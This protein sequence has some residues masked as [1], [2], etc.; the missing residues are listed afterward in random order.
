MKKGKARA[1]NIVAFNTMVFL[2]LRCS[3]S[4]TKK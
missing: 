4:A 1:N 3:V 2:E